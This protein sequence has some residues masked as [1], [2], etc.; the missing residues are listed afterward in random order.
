MLVAKCLGV[1]FQNTVMADKPT[2]HAPS[3]WLHRVNIGCLGGLRLHHEGIAPC[4]SDLCPDYRKLYLQQQTV[5]YES[6]AGIAVTTVSRAQNRPQ[7]A[8]HGL[9]AQ[10]GTVRALEVT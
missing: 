2:Q 10:A 6:T 3:A 4:G 9:N 5:H 8:W 1:L 7:D